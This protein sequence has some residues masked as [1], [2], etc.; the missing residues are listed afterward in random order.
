MKIKA[1]QPIDPERWEWPEPEQLP[2]DELDLEWL[3]YSVAGIIAA[4]VAVGSM[5]VFIF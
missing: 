4:S 2:A 5:I 3:L 1:G